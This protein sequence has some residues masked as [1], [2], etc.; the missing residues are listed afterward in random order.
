V[1]AHFHTKFEMAPQIMLPLRVVEAVV[2]R[3][4]LAQLP[5]FHLPAQCTSQCDLADVQY[6]VLAPQDPPPSQLQQPSG[7]DTCGCTV[8]DIAD[9]VDA[10]TS[11]MSTSDVDA[12]C[13]RVVS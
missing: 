2:S 5:T 10:G 12:T 7:A 13:P 9:I 3:F 6:D 8:V 11:I 4:P 1:E